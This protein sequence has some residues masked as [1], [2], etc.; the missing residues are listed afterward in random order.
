M[1][2]NAAALS[3]DVP[4]LRAALERGESPNAEEVRGCWLWSTQ[5]A[6]PRQLG[7]GA[8]LVRREHL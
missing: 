5:A 4:A 2:I 6:W 3:G 8:G 7:G 1:N